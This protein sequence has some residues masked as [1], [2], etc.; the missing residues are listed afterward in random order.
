MTDKGLRALK[1]FIPDTPALLAL[2]ITVIFTAIM[3]V[4]MFRGIPP[5]N[6]DAFMVGFGAVVVLLKDTYA[7]WNNTTK[8]GQERTDQLIEL[9][10]QSAPPTEEKK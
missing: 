5:G 2:A 6:R 7:H 4:L 9:A 8:A 10:K 1:G 3:I